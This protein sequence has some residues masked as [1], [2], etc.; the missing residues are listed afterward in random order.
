MPLFHVIWC[1]LSPFL[2]SSFL[3]RHLSPFTSII[4]WAS[5]FFC[6]LQ[7][8]PDGRLRRWYGFSF[9]EEFRFISL[10]TV[11]CRICHPRGLAFFLSPN[12]IEMA[13]GPDGA[14][15][16]THLVFCRHLSPYPLSSNHALTRVNQ[17]DS[18][19]QMTPTVRLFRRSQ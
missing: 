16:V 10:P 17:S 19:W 13:A 5:A 9:K 14:A 15:F 8:T 4:R 3:V 1:P 18:R 11:A 2:V 6:A 7:L 12:F